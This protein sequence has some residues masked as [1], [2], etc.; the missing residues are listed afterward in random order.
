MSNIAII[1][2][3]NLYLSGLVKLL[4]EEISEHGFSLYN[5]FELTHFKKKLNPQPDLLVVEITSDFDS[6]NLLNYLK[7]TNT[8]LAVL[9]T[10]ADEY[11]DDLIRLNIDGFFIIRWT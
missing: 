7:N 1:K 11:L 2:G 10:K 9:A 5:Y 6:Y 3:K 4:R 8:K